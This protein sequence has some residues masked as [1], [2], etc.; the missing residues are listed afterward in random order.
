MCR[1]LMRRNGPTEADYADR[2]VL[3]LSRGNL[4]VC[5]SRLIRPA[6]TG[7]QLRKHRIDASM[8]SIHPLRRH[9]EQAMRSSRRCAARKASI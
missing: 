5:P 7:R 6:V 9:D 3:R 4:S 8:G 1:P 2:E